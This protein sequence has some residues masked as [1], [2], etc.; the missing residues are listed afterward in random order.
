[1]SR[2][3]DD[4][5]TELV[6]RHLDGLATSEER[7]ALKEELESNPYRR[8][9]LVSLCRLHGRL[10][11]A[12]S[13]DHQKRLLSDAGI[14]A[15]PQ[16]ST[17]RATVRRRP[18]GPDRPFLVPAFV[19]AGI[20]AAGLLFLLLSPTAQDPAPLRRDKTAAAADAR[21][22]EAEARLRAIEEERRALTQ[23][24]APPTEPPVVKEKREQDLQALKKEQE[25]IEQELR[26]ATQA[27]PK[28]A[29][30]E[31]PRVAEKPPAPPEPAPVKQES[32]TQVAVAEV[33]E[34]AG[35]VFVAT[36]DGKSPLLA[37]ATLNSTQGVETGGGKSRV[38]LRFAD[39]TRV[40]VGPE[41]TVTEVRIDSGKRI[42]V[43]RGSI[44]ADVAKQPKDQPMIFSTPHAEARVLGTTLRLFVDREAGKGTRLDV[45]E[46]KVELKKLAGKSAMVETGHYAVAAAGAEPVPRVQEPPALRWLEIL[47]E[48]TISFGPEGRKLPQGVVIDSGEPFDAKRGYGWAGPNIKDVKLPD[49]PDLDFRRRTRL[50]GEERDLRA[51]RIAAGSPDH[52]TE[53]WSMKLPKGRYV[54]TICLGKHGDVSG[55]N[56]LQLQGIQVLDAVTTP[57][58]GHLEKE[59]PMEVKDGILKMV[60]GGIVN[61]DTALNFLRIKKALP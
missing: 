48:V 47:G 16:K 39:K 59:V 10:G 58:G 6:L 56:Y 8:S 57:V 18:P 52:L 27:A 60:V 51:S 7:A 44:A 5:F 34:V 11:E 53:S 41:T 50:E 17:R 40:E 42:L 36:K 22:R 35:D 2:F 3:T 12:L 43:A 33:V 28:P 19:A 30:Q 23:A 9:L 45:D 32:T 61:H 1:M 38:V 15:E 4:A 20:L 49:R 24:P 26:D 25:R 29:P 21:R 31:A 13:T 54:V 14:D 37:G 55:P 46:G